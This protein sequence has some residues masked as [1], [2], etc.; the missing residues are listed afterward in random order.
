MVAG[1]QRLNFAGNVI[2][3]RHHDD[4]WIVPREKGRSGQKIPTKNDDPVAPGASVFRMQALCLVTTRGLSMGALRWLENAP[5]AE[6]EPAAA[7]VTDGTRQFDRPED[8]V[9][10][11]PSCAVQGEIRRLRAESQLVRLAHLC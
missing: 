6:E 10:D 2:A 8:G 4:E 11:N 1:A 3:I 9:H 5:D 7:V